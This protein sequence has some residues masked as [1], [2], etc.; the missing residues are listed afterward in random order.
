MLW[1]QEVEA[2]G[3]VFDPVSGG[4]RTVQ[5]GKAL[6][7]LAQR[8]AADTQCSLV[9]RPRL[10][11]RRARFSGFKAEWDGQARQ[12]PVSGGFAGAT[13][14]DGHTVALSVELVGLV[15]DGHELLGV[16]EID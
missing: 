2:V 5:Y 6:A 7:A 13:R 4:M 9:L 12:S 3:G 10:L 16:N 14:F 15:P 11:T 8:I 1:Q